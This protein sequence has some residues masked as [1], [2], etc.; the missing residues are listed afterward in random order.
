MREHVS[1]IWN[2]FRYIF[3][4]TAIITLLGVMASWCISFYHKQEWKLPYHNEWFNEF[5]YMQEQHLEVSLTITKDRNNPIDKIPYIHRPL[6][7][8]FQALEVNNFL[9]CAFDEIY[10]EKDIQKLYDASWENSRYCV[11]RTCLI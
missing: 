4:A 2:I 10:P 11:F 1:K 9:T 3:I 5:S 8:Y 7:A 6:S